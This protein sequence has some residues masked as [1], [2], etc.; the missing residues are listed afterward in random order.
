MAGATQLYFV[1][2]LEIEEYY[3][4][5]KEILLFDG[6]KDLSRIFEMYLDEPLAISKISKAAQER[7]LSEHTYMH[8]AEKILSTLYSL[9]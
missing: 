4:P 9:S 7:T 2:S 8:R 3:E 1:E 5:D 6:Y